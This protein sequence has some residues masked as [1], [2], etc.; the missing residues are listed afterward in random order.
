MH[1]TF[2]DAEEQ[3]AWALICRA[4]NLRVLSVTN[5]PETYRDIEA[6]LDYFRGHDTPNPFRTVERFLATHLV[7]S[8]IDDLTQ[9]L[10]TA[11]R[12]FGRLRLT[13]FKVGGD[14]D[15]LTETQIMALLDV[16]ADAPLQCLSLCDIHC[17]PPR[18][19]HIIADAFPHLESLSLQYRQSVRQMRTSRSYWQGATWEYATALGRF[20]GLKH[21]WNQ[22]LQDH[23]APSGVLKYM[24]D[25]WPEDADVLSDSSI[26][27]T[28]F[29]GDW[30]CIVKLFAIHC[31]SLR[32]VTF[33]SGDESVYHYT[34]ERAGGVEVTE[35]A[36]YDNGGVTPQV[37]EM[38]DVYDPILYWPRV[39]SPSPLDM[40]EDVM[41]IDGEN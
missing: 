22:M 33:L 21:L 13:H 18:L 9:W 7:P 1:I 25:G 41:A 6:P 20:P 15:G 29:Y 23:E 14:E 24:E 26:D 8:E 34:V 36:W 38:L 19:I 11:K 12:T 28:E 31:K 30:A 39:F 10:L 2:G 35:V 5:A 3:T 16:L 4:P 40:A 37:L 17:A 27:V 32:T